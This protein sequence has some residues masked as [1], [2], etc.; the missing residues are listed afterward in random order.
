M[1]G[2][3]ATASNLSN[4]KGNGTSLDDVNFTLDQHVEEK[5]DVPIDESKEDFSEN[6]SNFMA[7]DRPYIRSPRRRGSSG[8]FSVLEE[9]FDDI[10]MDEDEDGDSQDAALDVGHDDD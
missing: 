7:R 3:T 4:V 2:L 1:Q 6:V 5:D 8:M 9:S 10:S